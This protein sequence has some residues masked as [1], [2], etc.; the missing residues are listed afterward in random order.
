MK[1]NPSQETN[2]PIEHLQPCEEEAFVTMMKKF[3]HRLS[4]VSSRICQNPADVEEVL[5]EVYLKV[6]RNVGGFRRESSL[7]TWLNRIV[8]NESL[9]KVRNEK[10]HQQCLPLDTLSLFRSSDPPS[11]HRQRRTPLDTLIHREPETLYGEG[12]HDREIPSNRPRERSRS[13]ECSEH[14]RFPH[15]SR[16]WRRCAYGVG[17]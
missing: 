17:I 9:M 13:D 5:Q 3:H 6:A 8:I 11:F 2:S 16:G 4:A 12:F 10:R 7:S 15:P 14:D 1:G